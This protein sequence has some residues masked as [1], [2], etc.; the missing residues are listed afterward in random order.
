LDSCTTQLLEQNQFRTNEN[1][2]VCW[3]PKQ[4]KRMKC[5]YVGKL[6]KGAKIGAC[7]KD[8]K[9]KDDLEYIEILF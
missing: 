4:S 2:H 8:R 5:D 9:M 1:S 7:Y 3:Y 6:G